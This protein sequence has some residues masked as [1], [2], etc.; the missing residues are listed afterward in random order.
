MFVPVDRVFVTIVRLEPSLTPYTSL[1]RVAKSSMEVCIPILVI[2]HLFNKKS[3]EVFIFEVLD[4]ARLP[5]L[6]F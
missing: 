5:N 6:E 2:K 3:C 1:N 4:K